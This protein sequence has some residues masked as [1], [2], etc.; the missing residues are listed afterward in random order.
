MEGGG[1]SSQMNKFEQVSNDHHQMSLAGEGIG[2]QGWCLGDGVSPQVWCAGGGG[3]T[4]PCDLFHVTYPHG[5]T[6]ACKNITF[7]KPLLIFIK[8]N[9]N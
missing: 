9:I 6:D 8:R 4:I 2:P 5:Q 7:H 3:G 1:V